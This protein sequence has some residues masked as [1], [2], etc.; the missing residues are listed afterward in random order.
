MDNE[1]STRS[2]IRLGL[3]LDSPAASKYVRDFAALVQSQ[4]NLTIATALLISPGKNYPANRTTLGN[5]FFK[6]IVAIERILL[7]KNKRHYDH[8]NTFDISTIIPGGPIIDLKDDGAWSTI[9]LLNIDLFIAFSK[10]VPQKLPA[11]ARLGVVRLTHSGELTK[12]GP[13]GFWEVYTRKDVT[14]FAVERLTS[15]AQATDVLLA[16]YAGTQFYYLLNQAT[17]F[18]KSHYYLFKT[19]ERIRC[20]SETPKDCADT[21]PSPAFPEIP[22]APQSISYLLGL[23][24]LIA[25]KTREK[26][27]NFERQ[28]NVGY[29]RS[30]WRRATSAY[31]CI[32]E[33]P[34]RHILA[35]PFVV[36][37]RGKTFCF[38][39]DLDGTT[40]RGKITVYSV[41]KDDPT[42]VGIALTED[43]H[44][45]FPYMFEYRGELYMCPET[46]EKQE[47]RIY[48]C[49]DFP[50]R[51]KLEKV[52]MKDISAVDT[53]LF[54]RNGR[55]WMMTNTDP[56]KW[57]DHSLELRIFSATSPLDDVWTPHPGNPFLI[58]A[59]RTRNGGI[60][61]EGDRIFRVAQG[62]GFDMYGKRTTINEIVQ[63]DENSYAERCIH[64]I[65]PV[66]ESGIAGT[67]HLHTNGAI[68]TFDFA[69]D[70]TMTKTVKRPKF[71]KIVNLR[72]C[73]SLGS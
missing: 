27:H 7:R 32:I 61:L 53:L 43:C 46:S 51:W 66:V 22:S 29:V 55:W 37:R 48:R 52:L 3:L 19:I 10:V 9:G 16:G 26:F 31:V 33:N 28:W 65:S 57:G 58:D 72:D 2:H 4:H 24:Y 15:T 50:L 13:A 59:S 56:A 54:E 71:T 8:F 64:E 73:Q 45:S 25:G 67:H 63:L 49:A 1:G 69:H 70:G 68:T 40:N 21:L 35:D 23:T 12:S 17:L 11:A 30:D 47:I 18:E 34:P 36:S 6:L 44:L 38:V 41:D 20:L 60:V 14:G 42:Y 39:E 62:Q 5:C